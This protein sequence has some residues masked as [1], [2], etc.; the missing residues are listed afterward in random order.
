MDEAEPDVQPPLHPARVAAHDTIGCLRKPEQ[1]EQLIDARLERASADTLD[2]ALQRQVFT[3]GRVAVNA[4]ALRHVAN[5]AADRVR[6]ADD[7]AASDLG[8][9]RVR[10]RQRREH[11][12]GRRLPGSVGA[13]QAEDLAGADPEANALERL[14]RAV[15]L[16]KFVDDDRV[17]AD[18]V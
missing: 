18:R 14:N 7:V 17:H 4:R 12:D 6:L 13:Q 2:P 3:A 8:M 16:P 11:L 10:L 1:L 15:P 9:A 5:R